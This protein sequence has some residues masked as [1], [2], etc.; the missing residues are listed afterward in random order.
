[1]D[2]TK[3][4]KRSNERSIRENYLLANCSDHPQASNEIWVPRNLLFRV[5][6]FPESLLNISFLFFFPEKLPG[7][8]CSKHLLRGGKQLS[9]RFSSST[10]GHDFVPFLNI[11]MSRFS[12]I[13]HSGNSFDGRIGQEGIHY[14]S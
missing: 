11:F 4:T 1:M 9:N 7:T 3:R 5:E 12:T 10:S 2:S 14:T 13:P 8:L 6:L